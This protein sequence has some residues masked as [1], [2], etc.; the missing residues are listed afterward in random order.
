MWIDL[1]L[2]LVKKFKMGVPSGFVIGDEKLS[3]IPC[4]VLKASRF[5]C[6]FLLLYRVV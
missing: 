1:S 6:L 5:F 2:P 3:A 4:D